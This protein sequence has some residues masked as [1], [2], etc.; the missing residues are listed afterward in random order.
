MGEA[1]D[2]ADQGGGEGDGGVQQGE[3]GGVEEGREEVGVLRLL[4]R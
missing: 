3:G 2:G 4:A 1:D